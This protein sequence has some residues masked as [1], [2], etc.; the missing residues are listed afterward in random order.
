MLMRELIIGGKYRHFK[1]NNY[2]VEGTAKDSETGETLV[3]Y[4]PLYGEGE[5]WARPLSMFLS[6][7]D[8]AKYP[9][10]KQK[11]RFELVE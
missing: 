3:L 10:V 7:V 9:E 4:R 5:L 2:R 8:H 11:Y 6:E 1:G